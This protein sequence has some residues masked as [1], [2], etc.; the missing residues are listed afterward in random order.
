LALTSICSRVSGGRVDIAAGRVADHRCEIADQENHVVAQILQLTH[1]VQYDGMAQM[2]VWRSRIQA[3]LDAQ[4]LA[5]FSARAS[6]C[7]N[8][9]SMSNSSTPRLV[10]AKRFLDSI[11]QGQWGLCW[12]VDCSTSIRYN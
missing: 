2:Q 5:A 11:G 6:F 3:Q 7:A 12:G 4:R 1:L 9:L 10:M 8:S